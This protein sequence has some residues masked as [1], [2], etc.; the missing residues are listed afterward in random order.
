MRRAARVFSITLA[1]VLFL[2]ACST[3]KRVGGTIVISTA[4]DADVLVPPLTLSLQGKQVVDQF[5]ALQPHFA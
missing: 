4:A 2:G 5:A 1:M 3:E